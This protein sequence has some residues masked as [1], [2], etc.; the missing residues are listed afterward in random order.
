MTC[1]FFSISSTLALLI[2][3]EPE[4]RLTRLFLSSFFFPTG[5]DICRAVAAARNDAVLCI[6][7]HTHDPGGD[8]PEEEH[9]GI[10]IIRSLFALF[11]TSF[12]NIRTVWLRYFWKVKKQ[13]MNGVSVNEWTKKTRFLVFKV[14]QAG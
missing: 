8:C 10:I 9:A 5:K 2:P 13:K 3:P 4:E 14:N 11:R 12:E 6:E 7:T 1:A